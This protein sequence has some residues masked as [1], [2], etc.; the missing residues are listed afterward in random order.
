MLQSLTSFHPPPRYAAKV[1]DSLRRPRA[2]RPHASRKPAST[3]Q[4]E[5]FPRSTPLSPRRATSLRSLIP[6]CLA[7]REPLST[8]ADISQCASLAYDFVCNGY[9]ARDSRSAGRIKCSSLTL[10][11]SMSK[12]YNPTRS[13]YWTPHRRNEYINDDVRQAPFF[14]GADNRSHLVETSLRFHVRTLFYSDAYP[15]CAS[16][17]C[18]DS[19]GFVRFRQSVNI[20]KDELDDV[21][22]VPVC[23]DRDP[24]PQYMSIEEDAG[25]LD[26]ARKGRWVSFDQALKYEDGN[27]D[28]QM[29]QPYSGAQLAQ[30]TALDITCISLTAFIGRGETVQ[31][32]WG[33]DKSHQN[34]SGPVWCRHKAGVVQADKPLIHYSRCAS[35]TFSSSP[36]IPSDWACISGN[37][38]HSDP[39]PATS[40]STCKG[41]QD[42]GVS[43]KKGIAASQDCPGSFFEGLQGQPKR[44]EGGDHNLLF[45]QLGT[46][47]QMSGHWHHC[48]PTAP[49]STHQAVRNS[50]SHCTHPQP[51]GHHA[52]RLTDGS[53]NPSPRSSQVKYLRR[54]HSTACNHQPLAQ[55]PRKANTRRPSPSSGEGC[56]RPNDAALCQNGGTTRKLCADIDC[57]VCRARSFA[58]SD[59]A[60]YMTDNPDVN[61][62]PPR[63]LFKSSNTKA[64]FKC[65][66]CD[67]TFQASLNDVTAGQWCPYC[68][69]RQLCDNE[70]CVAC[71]DRSFASSDK[72]QY[73]TDNPDVNSKPPRQL[74]KSSDTKA[75]FKCGECDHT[76]QASISSVTAGSWCPYCG[77]RQLCDDEGCVACLDRS[78]ASSDKAQYMTD[79]PDVNP[80][81]PRQLF[82]SS[83]TKAEFKC[84]EC[85]HTFQARL[86]DV[87]A[88]SWCPRCASSKLE[89]AFAHILETE[90]PHAMKSDH[91]VRISSLPRYTIDFKVLC[92]T[93]N[94]RFYVELDGAQHY[95]FKQN[96]RF[97]KKDIDPAECVEAFLKQ[98]ERDRM[99]E[100]ELVSRGELLFRVPYTCLDT[101]T[102]LECVR[103]MLEVREREPRGT[104]KVHRF[105]EERTYAMI[106]EWRQEQR[107]KEARQRAPEKGEEE[108][109]QGRE[110]GLDERENRNE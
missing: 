28:L 73:M 88:G 35:G 52:R 25:T 96:A 110:G 13:W 109:P 65:G 36:W 63:Q 94:K 107:D 105:D 8:S 77:A 69:G 50:T 60:K 9:E 19:T 22:M 27:V 20:A 14:G 48:T 47:E 62:K 56:Q 43:G 26:Q 30:E 32:A 58:S 108:T 12:K 67:H 15:Y 89:D 100:E 33:M 74:F 4:F 93:S 23:G 39:V 37:V 70:G 76:F 57:T 18:L 81:P 59:K 87:T 82:K 103:K 42:V 49:T 24:G 90:F 41:C 17:S 40:Q 78:F 75:E 29:H 16:G 85:D 3:L 5:R 11:S 44:I 97:F 104:G 54:Q 53:W 7:G 66:K 84:G 72:A 34:I 95:D 21:L 106:E 46:M 1:L 45:P 80:K 55:S 38:R 61:P 51:T 71:L 10:Q 91:Q 92:T 2:A 31:V 101:V 64:E 98:L 68:G 6:S 79:N 102:M 86:N 99:V 83:R